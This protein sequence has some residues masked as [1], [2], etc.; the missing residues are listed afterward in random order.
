MSRANCSSITDMPAP[1]STSNLMSWPL[2]WALTVR[3]RGL[4][5]LFV[6]LHCSSVG[7]EDSRFVWAGSG[8]WLGKLSLLTPVDSLP[9]EVLCFG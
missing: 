5:R 8:F 1:V 2:S 9:A 6:M 4:A 3:S 7:G